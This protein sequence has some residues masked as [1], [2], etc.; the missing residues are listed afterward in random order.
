M[1]P[2]TKARSAGATVDASFMYGQRDLFTSGL[3]AEIGPSAYAIWQAVKWHAD[4]STGKSFPSVRRLADMVGIN[5]ETA[6]KCLHVLEGAK[7]LRWTARGRGRSYIARERLDVRIGSAVV[8]TVL[9]DYVP[10]QIRDNAAAIAE[11]VQGKGPAEAMAGLGELEVEIVPGPGFVWDPES[12]SLK[13]KLPA[14]ALPREQRGEIPE[15]IRD[16]LKR[17]LKKDA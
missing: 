2:K 8:C 15:H 13:G 10:S 12:G 17:L 4:Y 5:R 16:E 9:L 6:S 14:G 3:V 11:A 1:K 7:L